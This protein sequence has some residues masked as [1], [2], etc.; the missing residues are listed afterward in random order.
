ME[1]VAPRSL[2]GPTAGSRPRV[3]VELLPCFEGYAGIPQETRLVYA[4]L[5]RSPALELGGLLNTYKGCRQSIGADRPAATRQSPRKRAAAASRARYRQARALIALQRSLEEP[6]ARSPLWRDLRKGGLRGRFARLAQTL[7]L[8]DRGELLEIDAGDFADALW[9]Q[10][11]AKTLPAEAAHDVLATRFLASSVSW[12]AAAGLCRRRRQAQ[13]LDT[14]GWDFFLC[15]KGCPYRLAPETRPVIRCHDAIPVFYPHTIADQTMHLR[16][17]YDSLRAGVRGGAYFACVSEPVRADL[18]R[19]APEAEERSCVIPDIVSP[20]FAPAP[21]PMERVEEIMDLRACPESLVMPRP[22][23]RRA[24]LRKPPKGYLLA[25]STLEPRKNYA[26]LLQAFEEANREAGP[27]QLVLVANLGWRYEGVIEEIKKLVR[28]GSVRHL[29]GVPLPELR[30]LYANAHAV[31]CPSRSEGFDLAGVEAML[32]GTP[33]L[34]SDIPVHRWVYGDAA[35]YFHAYD[36]DSLARTL[37][38]A[39]RSP[40]AEGTLAALRARG[41]KHGRQFLPDAVGPKWEALFDRLMAEKHAGIPL[42]ARPAVQ[43]AE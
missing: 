7:G 31:V 18:L 10:L 32:C 9:M 3:L 36:A 14:R 11:F 2:R 23:A 5:A 1:N 35:R 24:A 20:A 6:K 22:D 30:V 17:Y 33:V 16:T 4:L 40:A 21:R 13:P 41:L 43:A 34:A 26:A 27:F 38:E 39:M 12:A 19:L 29:V 25:V 8:G 37:V 42:P 15:Q 28:A